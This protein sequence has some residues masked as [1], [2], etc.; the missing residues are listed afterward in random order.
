MPE[1]NLS[2]EEK[3]AT[4]FWPRIAGLPILP[5]DSKSKECHYPGWSTADLD[6]VNFEEN[7]A[8]GLYD[9]GVSGTNW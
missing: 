6:N 8:N 9:K 3:E 7:L 5:H 4:L 2:A 1:S